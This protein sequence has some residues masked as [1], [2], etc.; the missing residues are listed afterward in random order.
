M[1][2]KLRTAIAVSLM[3]CTAEGAAVLPARAQSAAD[4][5][6]SY[7]DWSV[8]VA[9]NPKECYIVSPPKSSKATRDGKAVD[10]DRGDIR[11]FVTYRPAENVS[12]EVSFS[13]GYPF[14]DGTAVKLK[15]GSTEFSL[16]PGGGDANSWAWPASPQV[17]SKIVAALRG[18]STAAVTGT[19]SRGT[20]T[21]DS[22]SLA[23]F[24]A[25]VQD[26]AARCK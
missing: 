7:T 10:V 4:R 9:G 14:R 3:L 1:M 24:T 26:A 25:A 6:A 11:L 5:V 16:S 13:G 15:V 18:G 22:F 23:G 17:D 19:S 12:G 20:V 8:F 21:V 2:P